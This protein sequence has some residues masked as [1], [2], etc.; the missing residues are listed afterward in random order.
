MAA[1]FDPAGRGELGHAWDLEAGALP[2]RT[3]RDSDGIIA[4]ARAGDLGGLLIAGVDLNDLADPRAAE[5]ALD[6]AGFVVSLEMRTSSVT[7]RADVVLPIAPSVEKAG[8]YVDW[9]GRVRPFE[10]VL[11]TAAMSDAR[12][13][14]A[15][16]RE[17]GVEL[18]AG[19]VT[20]VRAELAALARM[21][22]PTT[23]PVG[24]IEKGPGVLGAPA[25]TCRPP[26]PSA[27]PVARPFWPPGTI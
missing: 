9:E 11:K 1:G 22:M 16:A 23:S 8:S 14:D 18:A 26:S 3:G 25:R 7:R 13:L 2:S 27:R 21:P 24:A 15:I 20:R 6:R 12:V 19:D 17:M 4:A 10:T 5:E